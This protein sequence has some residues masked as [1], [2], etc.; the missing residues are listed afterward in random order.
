MFE[1]VRRHQRIFLGI[2]LLLIIPSFVVVGAW[3]MI[4]PRSDAN[5]VAKVGRQKIQLQQ[6]ERAHQQ[7]LDQVRAQLGG[8]VDP[9]MFD[10]PASRLATLNDLVTRQVLL[11]SAVKMRLGVSDAQMREVIA[12]IPA[13][14][15]DGK[16]DMARYQQALKAQG[17]TA[18][19][20]EQSVRAD[21]ITEMMPAAIAR[22]NLVPRSVARRLAQTG[23]ESRSVRIK[24]FAASEFMASAQVTDAEI[25]AFYKTNAAQFQTPDEVDIAIVAFT[26]PGSA[27]Q[28]EQFSNLVYEQSDSLEPAARKLNLPVQNVRGIRREGPTGKV[29]AELQ[30]VLA[31]PKMLAAIFSADALVNKRNTEA[32]E[33]APGVLASARVTAHRPAAPIALASVKNDISQALRSQKARQQASDAANAAQQA[34]ASSKALPSGI[35]AAKPL[36]REN[37]GKPSAELPVD[38]QQAIFSADIRS[39]PAVVSVPADARTGAAWLAVIDSAQI[40]AADAGAVKDSLGRELQRLEQALARETLDRW[41][42]LRRNEAGVEVFADRLAK[43][44]NR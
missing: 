4:S 42:L 21:L 25:E 2:V 17:L 27:D 10:T 32:V 8:R 9:A 29:A 16:F 41:V 11:D 37:L 33:I 15:K 40:P 20:F 31:N 35:S 24:K 22:T 44:Q 7:T 28:V 3:D 34:F 23:L 36:V 13:V 26:K 6:W 39:L 30:P 38:L 18:E 12:G 5:T 14:Q 43:A 1:S 19:A